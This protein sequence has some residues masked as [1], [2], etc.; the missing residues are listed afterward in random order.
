VRLFVARARALRP[1]FRLT[2]ETAA[3]VAA[4]CRRVE[5]LPLALELAA[6]R[7]LLLPP[8]LLLSRLERRL[9]LLSDGPRD[10]PP[11]HQTLHRAIAWSYDL[12]PEPEQ[13]LFRRLA[14]FAGG[15]TLAAGVAVCGAPGL[16]A[17][18]TAPD[19]PRDA[20]AADLG[21]L[22]LLGSLADKS[23][24]RPE[25]R[26]PPDDRVRRAPAEAPGA[27]PRLVMLETLREFAL[28]RL[29]AC[30]E[31]EAVRRWHAGYYL[32]LAETADPDGTA[33]PDPAAA[34]R[35]WPTAAWLDR[36]EAE[37]DNLRQALRWWE[38]RGRAGEPEPGL[39]L[40]GALWPFWFERGHWREGRD[41]LD[42]LLTAGAHAPPAARA[43][44]LKGA[45]YPT[46]NA[47]TPDR[48]QA[49]L[50][51]L[52]ALSRARGDRRGEA[53]ALLSLGFLA[54]NRVDNAR[55]R[56]LAEACLAVA[57]PA[58]AEVEAAWALHLLGRV[59][60]HEGQDERARAFGDESL[61]RFR[62]LGHRTALA[63]T[64]RLQGE[65]AR[66]RGDPAAAA[67]AFAEGLRLSREAGDVA[68][69]AAG[70]RRCAAAAL[71]VGDGPRARALLRESLV[72]H[73]DAGDTRG[74]AECLLGL[75]SA[76]AATG[77]PLQACRLY[78]AARAQLDG[79]RMP[80]EPVDR[81]AHERRLVA[82]RTALGE[83]A[84]AAAWAEGHATPL[85]QVIT[86]ALGAAAG[87]APGAA[88][89]GAAPLTPRQLEVA[90]LVARGLSSREIATG[91]SITERTAENHVEHILTRLGFH[92]RAQ[93]A[94]W[95][96]EHGLANGPLPAVELDG[97]AAGAA[98]GR[99][100]RR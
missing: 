44:A 17:L 64:L 57:R 9:P 25:D 75:A 72:L 69:I 10:A 85:E 31:A 22:G 67:G 96:V 93:I 47:E 1:E 54:A 36:M 35:A 94:A 95:T 12:L 87:A 48:A 20:A 68:G 40:A 49:R 39:R 88:A 42:R 27:E 53:S 74:V 77:Q 98:P 33:G 51:E 26:P 19:G 61:R 6:A 21:G 58:G 99:R 2:A 71:D 70:L 32:A 52:L 5:G 4:I 76:A 90:R 23:L 29:E 83:P 15:C 3:A 59:A 50:D 46:W 89:P 11:R 43:A 79:G 84:F 18:G 13:A 80:T 73:R 38:A 30:G 16:P 8:P 91:L 86:A 24:L 97:T 7:T 81:D 28:E 100:G 55:A 37:H 14:V 45:G 92:S 66:R 78:G 65:L 63:V 34:P 62:A 82:L 60:L 41:W 56:R